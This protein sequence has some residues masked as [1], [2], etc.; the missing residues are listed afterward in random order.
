M[1]KSKLEILLYFEIIGSC[2]TLPLSLIKPLNR[3]YS[4]I[5]YRDFQFCNQLGEHA[6]Y[7]K[8]I[9]QLK[10][11]LSKI[12][13]TIYFQLVILGGLINKDEHITAFSFECTSE[14]F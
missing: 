7:I 5:L 11:D 14:R 10:A 9:M 1:S 12:K 3:I 13:P 4:T 6:L 8:K 2:K